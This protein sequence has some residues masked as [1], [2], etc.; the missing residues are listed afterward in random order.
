MPAGKLQVLPLVGLG[1]FGINCMAFRWGDD[2][3]VVDAS[4]MF[5]EAELLGVD[6]VVPTSPI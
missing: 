5:P 3:M 4:I 6:I 1:G 2:I